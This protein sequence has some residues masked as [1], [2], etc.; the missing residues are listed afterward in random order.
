MSFSEVCVIKFVKEMNSELNLE[1][2][3]IVNNVLRDVSLVET[4]PSVSLVNQV[5]RSLTTGYVCSSVHM[6]S[7][8]IQE[9][10]FVITVNQVVQ[11]AAASINVMSV[12]VVT[13]SSMVGAT[14]TVSA[15]NSGE[16]KHRITYVKHVLTTVPPVKILAFV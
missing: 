5:M 2:A 16:L 7:L 11:N 6:V 1:T 14:L 9:L 10:L 12:K 13:P 8:E 15:T 3:T 4:T